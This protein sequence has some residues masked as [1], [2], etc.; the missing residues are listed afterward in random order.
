ML[1][2]TQCHSAETLAS[3]H[4]V[5]VIQHIENL[6]QANLRRPHKMLDSRMLL[7]KWQLCIRCRLRRSLGKSSQRLRMCFDTLRQ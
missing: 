4:V 1:F 6:P 2:L 5:E 7:L 3:D